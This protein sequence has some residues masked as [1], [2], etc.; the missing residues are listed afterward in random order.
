MPGRIEACLD[1]VENYPYLE[2]APP[3]IALYKEAVSKAIERLL[4]VKHKVPAVIVLK[5]S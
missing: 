1:E 4:G 2:A 5:L 3:E